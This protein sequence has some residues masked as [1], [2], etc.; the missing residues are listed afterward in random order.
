MFQIRQR[1]STIGREVSG[2]LT[3][4]MA[5]SY[6]LFVQPALLRRTGIAIGFVSYAF[7]KLVTGRV[8]ECPPIVY[9]FAVLFVVRYLV[10]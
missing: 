2:G 3:T 7:M 8:R 1:G 4:F 6:I 5:M 9:V 10:A